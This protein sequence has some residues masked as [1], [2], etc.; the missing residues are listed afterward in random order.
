MTEHDVRLGAAIAEA[1][2]AAARHLSSLG[3]SPGSSGNLSAIDGDTLVLT[4]TGSSLARVRTEDLAVVSLSGEVLTGRPSKELPLHLAA[5][6]A[7]P[8]A[9]A[10]VHLHSPAA[11][12]ISCIEPEGE[13]PLLPV[14]PYHAMRL[15]RVPLLAYA[16]P[17][18]SEL[19]AGVETAAGKSGALLLGN[20]GSVTV[21]GTL[22]AAVD[23]A[24]EL[25]A[26]SGLQLTLAGRVIRPLPPGEAERL[27]SRPH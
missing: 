17:G 27:A 25:E 15:G 3:L 2:V 16:P 23:L 18:S 26:A 4:P 24:E 5:Y 8:D 22:D 13:H 11:T 12:A 21:G 14:T 1:L 7:R 9:R 20:H 19:A 6:R 10:V